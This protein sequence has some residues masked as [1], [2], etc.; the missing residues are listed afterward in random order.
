VGATGAITAGHLGHQRRVVTGLPSYGNRSRNFVLGPH[1][2]GVL[3]G[4]SMHVLLGLGLPP[5]RRGELGPA[6]ADLGNLLRLSPTGHRRPV[7]DISAY[8]Q[9]HDPDQGI[10]G[11]RV[12]SDPFGL[13]QEGPRTFVTDAAGNS[14]LA[15]YP[16]GRITTVA[17]F[18][19]TVDPATGDAVDAVPT[20][21][22]RGPDGAL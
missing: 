16:G 3:P 21:V 20:S 10:P 1:D 15:V 17:V 18:P 6:G 22:V 19:D 13:L 9:E 4:R 2:I 11:A 5:D 14:L 12:E 8:E 7:A